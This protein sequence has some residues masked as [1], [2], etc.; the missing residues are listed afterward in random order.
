MTGHGAGTSSKFIL[1]SAIVGEVYGAEGGAYTPIQYRIG[2]RREP[3]EYFVG[4]VTWSQAFDGEPS[5]GF[6]VGILAFS[7]RFAC[8][9]GCAPH[10]YDD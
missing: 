10:E 1:K 7:P 2:V 6:E 5:G 8:F 9:G 4:A 3:S